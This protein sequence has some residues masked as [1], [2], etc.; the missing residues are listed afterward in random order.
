MDAPDAN[1]GTAED[2]VAA[3][4]AAGLDAI[5]ITDHNTATWC[6]QVSAA[7]DGTDLV[8]L[9]GVEI[10]TTEGHLLAIWE[11]A[12]EAAVIDELLVTLGIKKA[13]RG[14]LD[15][16]AK[17]GF[18]DTAKHIVDAGGIAIA[19]HI[20]KPKGLLGISVAAHQK[21]TL[22]EPCL[23][24]VEVFDLST[25][26]K[27][28]AKLGDERTM[29]Y[30][31]GSDTWD[32]AL[33]Q[34]AM[35]GIGGRRTWIKATR[36]DLVGIKHALADPELRIRLGTAPP[37]PT[38]PTIDGV[39]LIGGFLGGQKIALCPDLNCLLGGTGAGKSLVL[40]AIRYALDQQVDKAAFPEIHKEVQSRLKSAL[41]AGAVKLHISAN[42]HRYRIERPFSIDSNPSPVV[43]QETGDEWATIDALPSELLTIAAFSQG[44]VLEY[45]RQL[46]AGCHW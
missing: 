42:R 10:S 30:I 15:I 33:S 1:Y 20:D 7:A 23:S 45:S 6:D 40:E 24:A 35:T 37:Q 39:E 3:A 29:A 4:L 22:L 36:P 12:T 32:A 38:Y 14:K 17:S 34:H 41:G 18:A 9:P 2:L 21:R 28:D 16:A 11:A 27:V 5:A 25:C 26:E 19:A 31:Q 44:E 13:D 8:V 43:H 46:L